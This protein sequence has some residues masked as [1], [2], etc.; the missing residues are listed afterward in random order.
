MT[1]VRASWD[2]SGSVAAWQAPFPPDASADSIDFAA[3]DDSGRPFDP[4]RFFRWRC[5]RDY[6]S[7]LAGARFAP[8]L[9]AVH[10]LLGASAPIDVSASGAL[11]R[12]RDGRDVPDTLQAFLT[13]P[14]GFV[15]ALSSSLNGVSSRT[16][17]MIGTDGTLSIHERGITVSSD[18]QV[19]RYPDVGETWPKEYRDWFYMMH[20]MTP[21]GQVRGLPAPERTS[22]RIELPPDALVPPAH[23]IEF[24]DCVRTRRQP[25]ESLDIALNAAEA[26]I[27]ADD[28]T[29]ARLPGRK[30]A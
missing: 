17:D 2:S 19:E 18:P 30:E 3:F 28:L 22:E 24:V 23:L 27:R 10:W 20:G 8:Q 14:E 9:T 1:L 11:L 4:H 6:G 29:V 7:G 21:Q 26:A 16:L 25:K 15:V 5:Y 12:W 13:Y